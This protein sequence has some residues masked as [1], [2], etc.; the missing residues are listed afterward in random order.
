MTG[1]TEPTNE[2]M[3]N[4][5]G[6]ASWHGCVYASIHLLLLCVVFAAVKLHL[7][8]MFEHTLHIALWKYAVTEANYWIISVVHAPHISIETHIQLTASLYHYLRPLLLVLL[9][10]VC[11]SCKFQWQILSALIKHINT[12]ACVRVCM[13]RLKT[14]STSLLIQH[15]S[16]SRA[17]HIVQSPLIS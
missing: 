6:N 12:C 1:N 3:Q 15:R 14:H 9:L 17:Y 7:V 8:D 2:R 13:C 4:R 5:N 16:T 10:F 11:M